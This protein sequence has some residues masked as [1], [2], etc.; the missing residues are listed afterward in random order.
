MDA[1]E[2]FARYRIA[3]RR[4]SGGWREHLYCTRLPSECISVITYRHAQN[5]PT[6]DQEP[7]K[8]GQSSAE[9]SGNRATN[10]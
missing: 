7:V 3:Y 2:G 5:V 8:Y 10:P 9:R 6:L 4:E 1:V